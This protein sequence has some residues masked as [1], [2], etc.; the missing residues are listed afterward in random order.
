M[1]TNAAEREVIAQNIMKRGIAVI[2]IANP[3]GPDVDAILV[4]PASYHIP[5]NATD[6]H[7]WYEM[8]GDG[9]NSA[10]LP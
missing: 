3:R 7:V 5:A 6:V 9:A 1:P 4:K 8:T 10:Y 2:A